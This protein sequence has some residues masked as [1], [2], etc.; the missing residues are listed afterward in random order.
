MVNEKVEYGGFLAVLYRKPL[1]D[2]LLRTKEKF[3]GAKLFLGGCGWVEGL[4][5][6]K[7]LK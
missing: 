5:E 2:C 4:V 3:T 7:V 6:K 1:K